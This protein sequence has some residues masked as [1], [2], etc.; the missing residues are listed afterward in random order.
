MIDPDPMTERNIAVLTNPLSGHGHACGVTKRAL[1]RFQQR[2]VE[3][4]ELVG[5]DTAHTEE[6]VHACI[7]N[8]TEVLVVVGGDGVISLALQAIAHTDVVLGIVPAGT[9]NDHARQFHIPC[10]NP[11][12]AVD[13][14]LAGHIHTVDIGCIRGSDGTMRLFGTVAAMGFDSAVSER[15]NRLRWPHGQMRYIVAILTELIRF[16]PLAFHVVIDEQPEI[17]AE[18]TLVACGNTRSYGGGMMICP[19]ADPTD[20]LLDITMVGSVSRYKLLRLFPKVFSGAHIELPDVV[21]AR[22]H[23]IALDAAGGFGTAEMYAYA[24]GERV[25]PLPVELSVAPG[26]LR[27]CVGST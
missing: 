13:V 11:E 12:A 8:G 17:T 20:G 26:A 3:V 14:I 16:R 23:T 18:L 9:G 27:V 1:A 2:G 10:D 7:K 5:R 6:L 21:T 19:N 25:C 22:A 4:V 15:A 24:D